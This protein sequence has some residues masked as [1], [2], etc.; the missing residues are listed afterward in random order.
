MEIKQHTPEQQIGQRR[1]QR[2]ILKKI[3]IP[4]CLECSTRSSQ[5]EF[6]SNKRLYLCK[7]KRPQINNTSLHLKELEKEEQTKPQVRRG[8]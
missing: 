2:E 1:N 7:E 3:C 8:K 6:Y 4:N 5:W